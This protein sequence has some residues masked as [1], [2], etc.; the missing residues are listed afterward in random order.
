MTILVLYHVYFFVSCLKYIL[1]YSYSNGYTYFFKDDL[2]YR[3]NPTTASV[4]HG[5]PAPMNQYWTGIPEKIQ[6]AFTWYNG[7]V[8]FY[9]DDK[10]TFFTPTAN[11]NAQKPSS[12]KSIKLWWE[13]PQKF[14]GYSVFR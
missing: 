3:F 12:P 11:H 9:K 5:Y 2:Y 8:Y 1:H 10:F 14:N 6:G 13:N 4:D 7:G